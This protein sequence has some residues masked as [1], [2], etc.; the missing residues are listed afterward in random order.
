MAEEPTRP[1]ITIQDVAKAAYHG[2]ISQLAVE[3][4][5]LIHRGR[6]TIVITSL[7][8]PNMMW[9]LKLEEL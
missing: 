9:A 6:R 4:R 1:P 5:A 7:E 3:G 2:G 8:Q